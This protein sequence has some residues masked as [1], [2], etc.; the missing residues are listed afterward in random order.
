MPAKQT[1]PAP[2]ATLEWPAVLAWRLEQQHLARHA[3]R[4]ELLAVVSDLCG[5]HAQVLSSAE[6]T[7]WAR[8]D[9]L[10]PGDLADALWETRSLVKTWAMRG[11][12]HLLPSGEFPAWVAAL[13]SRTPRQDSAAFQK[14]FG[15]TVADMDAINAA[16]PAA[17]DGRALTRDELASE[18]GRITGSAALGDK[19]RHSWGALLKPA[20]FNGLLCFAPGEGSCIRFTLPATWLG[21]QPAIAPD[22]AIR[23]A[24][25][26][27]FHAYGPARREDMARWFGV[28]AASEASA[29]LAALG[30]ELVPVEIEGAAFWALAENVSGMAGRAPSEAVR[31]LPGFDQYVVNAT[32]GIEA[33]LPARHKAAV[34]RP[35]GWI[36]PV[37]LVGGEIRGT[38]RHERTG[39]RLL[40]ELTPF[41]P[42]ARRVRAAAESEAERLRYFLGGDL[43]VTWAG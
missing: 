12:L 29:M 42:V 8:L 16:I 36:S 15:V 1:T 14:Y 20:A 33:I 3:S 32:R 6:A 17:L 37:L 39:K 34:F 30:D 21:P 10:Q 5:L 43:T 19:L 24:V 9:G 23:F 11:T 18:V 28:R 31:L 2:I 25:R 13:G 4:D 35:Q 22:D 40:V 27:Y 7:L 38:W 41:A 26:R